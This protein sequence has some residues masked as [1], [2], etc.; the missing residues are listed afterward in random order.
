MAAANSSALFAL[1]ISS[2]VTAVKFLP[3]FYCLHGAAIFCRRRLNFKARPP[4]KLHGSAKGVARAGCSQATE[5]SLH[6]EQTGTV[7]ITADHTPLSE[8]AQ[9]ST[10]SI[11]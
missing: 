8:L 3:V 6:A 5:G 2:L 4:G 9:A 7:T 10:R 11:R 1:S